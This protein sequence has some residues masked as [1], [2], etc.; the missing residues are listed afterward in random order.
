MA[1]RKRNVLLNTPVWIDFD[2][3]HQRNARNAIASLALPESMDQLGIGIFRD[4]L[5]N[6]LFPGTTVTMTRAVYLELLPVFM[7]QTEK[8]LLDIRDK[9]ANADLPSLYRKK[10]YK[11]QK[12]FCSKNKNKTGIIGNSKDGE[13]QRQPWE[14]Y[15]NF[16]M[17]WDLIPSFGEVMSLNSYVQSACE[18]IRNFSE[19]N[20]IDERWKDHWVESRKIPEKEADMI[21]LTQAGKNFVLEKIKGGDSLLSKLTENDTVDKVKFSDLVRTPPEGFAD[22]NV[23]KEASFFYYFTRT[24][25]AGYNLLLNATDDNERFLCETIA[26]LKDQ[27]NGK[28]LLEAVFKKVSNPKYNQ[29]KGLLRNWF[30]ACLA[31]SFDM[32]ALKHIVDEEILCKSEIKAN[33]L[34]FKDETDFS[35]GHI[36]EKISQD[37]NEKREWVGMRELD[38]RCYQSTRLLHHLLTDNYADDEENGADQNGN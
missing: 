6:L 33:C 22:T 19:K 4:A 28:D 21:D 25:F 8:E 9:N 36:R 11:R 26:D 34:P 13:V 30:N 10:M 16:L 7:Y 12:D 20:D 18:K 15:W 17:I 1:Y 29:R 31:P 32:K 38:Y 5:S 24:A 37:E 35:M 2:P 3:A 27:P 23:W 14:I